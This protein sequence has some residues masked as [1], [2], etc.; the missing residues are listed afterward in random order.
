MGRACSA[1]GGDEWRK[2]GFG[3]ENTWETQAQMGGQY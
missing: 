2:K 1:Y 3:G